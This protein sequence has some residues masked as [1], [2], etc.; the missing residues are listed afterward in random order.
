[1]LEQIL[2][3]VCSSGNKFKLAWLMREK[4]VSF[5]VSCNK[6]IVTAHSAHALKFLLKIIALLAY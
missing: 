4:I 2:S 1:M 5:E 6:K 3:A